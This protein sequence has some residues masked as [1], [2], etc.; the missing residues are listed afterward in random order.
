MVHTKEIYC[1]AMGTAAILLKATS[2]SQT[3]LLLPVCGEMK[4]TENHPLS[5]S[6]ILDKLFC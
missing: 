5:I 1:T 4:S 6:W 3:S 2:T